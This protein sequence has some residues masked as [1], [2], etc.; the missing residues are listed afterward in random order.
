MKSIYFQVLIGVFV[1]MLCGCK[2]KQSA[3]QEAYEFAQ[4]RSITPISPTDK[5][6]PTVLNDA[7]FQVERVTAVDGREIKQYS[8][9]VGSFIN[10]TNAESLKN[11]MQAT[12]YSPILAQ[13]GK[14]MY[15]VIAATFDNKSDAYAERDSIKKRYPELNS[16]LLLENAITPSA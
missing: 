15:R 8:V 14:G 3:Y 2:A 11:R 16:I 10:K 7:D 9:V 12:G 1:I 6:T 5:K 4:A 13:N